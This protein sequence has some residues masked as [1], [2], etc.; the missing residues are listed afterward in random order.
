[1]SKKTDYYER[2]ESW[3]ADTRLMAAR[4]RRIAWTIAGVAVAV[5]AFEAVALALLVPLKTVQPI[6]LLV[7]RQT[8]YVQALDP[9]QPRRVNADEALTQSSLAQYVAAREGFDRATVRVD[10]RKVA[11][12]S[13]GRARASYVG[14]MPVTN[15]SSPFRRYP[16]GATV[17]VRVK[18]VSRLSQGT[19][20]VRFDTQL[21]DRSGR[22]ETSQPWISVVRYHYSDAP[23]SLEDRLVNPL[24]FQ[25]T[26]YRRDAEAPASPEALPS[27]SRVDE[28]AGGSADA[29]GTLRGISPPEGSAGARGQVAVAARSRVV[30][31]NL[32]PKGS[33]LSPP[34]GTQ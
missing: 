10:Y 32:V 21:Q 30:P 17:I 16:G 27:G 13:A 5:A 11:L 14:T 12:W 23:M 8:G 3:A 18:S 1:M 33:P 25:V 15:P 24:G 26:G 34:Q 29:Y 28:A 9:L 6:T 4:S 19:A 31:N 22:V 7:D 2:A 20:M